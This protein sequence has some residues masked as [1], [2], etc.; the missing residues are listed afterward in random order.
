[1]KDNI[2]T[3][4]ITAMAAI[5]PVDNPDG[6]G[7]ATEEGVVRVDEVGLEVVDIGRSVLCQFIWNKGA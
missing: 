1:M 7:V 3:G 2:T 5:T 4:M 6:L